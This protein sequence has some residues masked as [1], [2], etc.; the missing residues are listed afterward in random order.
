MKVLFCVSEAVPLAK[1]GGLA[2]VGGALPAALMELGT[3][4]RLALPRDR[5]IGLAGPRPGG[6]VEVQGGPEPL[7]AA[8]LDGKM[9]DPGVPAGLSDHRGVVNRGRPDGAGWR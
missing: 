2:D 3:D 5:G 4:V 1:T 7:P 6:K 9:P 8:L